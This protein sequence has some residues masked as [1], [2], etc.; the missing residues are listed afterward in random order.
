M[1][2]WTAYSTNMSLITQPSKILN[3]HIIYFVI[4]WK[5]GYADILVQKINCY[6]QFRYSDVKRTH[7]LYCF[8]YNIYYLYI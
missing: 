3:G 6:Q 1:I 4:V 2:K 7:I 8:F 5:L